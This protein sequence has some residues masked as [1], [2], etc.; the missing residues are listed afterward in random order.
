M[1]NTLQLILLLP[2]IL[3]FSFES[4]SAIAESDLWD[5]EQSIQET[6]SDIDSHDIDWAIYK[7]ELTSLPRFPEEQYTSSDA[8]IIKA[9]LTY[10]LIRAPPLFDI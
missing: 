10:S 1:K 6:I 2:C 9:T 5:V 3:L 4:N 8:S 7:Y